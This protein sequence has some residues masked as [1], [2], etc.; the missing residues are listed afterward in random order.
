ML[1]QG[2]MT[3]LQA[4]GCATLQGARYLGM[5][6]DLG[7]LEPGKL[8][9]LAVLERNPLEDIRVSDQVR[10]VMLNGR[11]YDAHTQ[12]QIAPDARKRGPLYWEEG[13]LELPAMPAK[14]VR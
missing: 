4:I 10:L 1:V 6:R 13:G 5:D 9:D 11:L 2:G 14:G 8:A 12:D 7:S 3:P